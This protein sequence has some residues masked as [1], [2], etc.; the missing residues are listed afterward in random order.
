M[1]THTIERNFP[2]GYWTASDIHNGYLIRATAVTKREAIA[3]LM[4]KK[5]KQ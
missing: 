1:N 3:L 5:G 4:A 2:S